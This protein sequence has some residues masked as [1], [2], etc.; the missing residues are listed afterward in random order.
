MGCGVYF[1]P[2]I[3]MYSAHQIFFTLNRAVLITTSVMACR[4][5]ISSYIEKKFNVTV[6]KLSLLLLHV[7]S[8]MNINRPSVATVLDIHT[9]KI[10]LHVQN[11]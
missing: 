8:Y 2:R 1:P 4:V 10:L 9:F 7:I 11:F 3:L 5:R 6:L